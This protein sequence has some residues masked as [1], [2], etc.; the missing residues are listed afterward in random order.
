MAKKILVTRLDVPKEAVDFTSCV[1]RVYTQISGNQLPEVN[2]AR[3]KA[4]LK[5]LEP[6]TK[7]DSPGSKPDKA[8]HFHLDVDFSKKPVNG[9]TF[10]ELLTQ[11]ID[12]LILVET[13]KGLSY[14]NSF[15]SAA[16]ALFR[17]SDPTQKDL[18]ETAQKVIS[19]VRT[20]TEATA[21]FPDNL[22]ELIKELNPGMLRFKQ[23]KNEDGDLVETDEKVVD[24][25]KFPV[26]D[27]LAL[28]VYPNLMIAMTAHACLGA[29][30]YRSWKQ[31]QG[32]KFSKALDTEK[33]AKE[34]AER[35]KQDVL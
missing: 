3:T 11:K 30:G 26:K 29:D 24:G 28:S 25:K 5:P 12:P 27:V 34:E 16:Q 15:K 14:D 31:S 22:V 20:R 8:Y 23:V 32:A 19:T 1:C 33:S 21:A 4:G 13:I 35:A 18:D 10:G 6:N 17:I 7:S 9:K 2:E